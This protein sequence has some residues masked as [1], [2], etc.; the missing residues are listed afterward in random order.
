MAQM[1]NMSVGEFVNQI[2]RKELH[3]SEMLSHVDC[4]SVS[5][6]GSA[7]P[8]LVHVVTKVDVFQCMK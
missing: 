2:W 8:G 4:M 1:Q 6:D 7:H 5:H 3:S